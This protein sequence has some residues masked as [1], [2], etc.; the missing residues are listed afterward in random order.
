[1]THVV[2]QETELWD[3]RDIRLAN[4]KNPCQGRLEV[5]FNGTWGTVCSDSFVMKNAE[6]VCTQLNCGSAASVK[7]IAAFGEGSGPIWLDDVKCRSDDSLLWQCPSSPWGQH[8]CNH[9]EDVAVICS[10][11]HPSKNRIEGNRKE[12]IIYSVPEISELR[13]VA[14]F[15]NCSGRVEVFFGGTWGTL[16]DDSWDSQDAAVVCKQLN[17]GYPVLASGGRMFAQGNGTIWMDEVK[18]K[19]SEFFLWDCQF[20]A[21]GRHD[22][23]YKE[24]VGVICSGY[25]PHA[26]PFSYL[27]VFIYVTPCILGSLLVV[28][29]LYLVK[30]LLRGFR[31][32]VRKLQPSLTGFPEPFYEE[33]GIQESGA[34]LDSQSLGSENKLQYYVD[35]DLHEHKNENV[36]G[37]FS[38]PDGDF[39]EEY[40]DAE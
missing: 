33:I 20:S 15:D 14:G 12:T 21:M 16:C 28:M 10:E 18:C 1:M 4:G 38:P 5:F 6:V 2:C 37:A 40:D 19:G 26:A 31:N 32:G 9:G 30:G 36:E 17:C 3:H 13:L 34:V 23:G 39:G 29:S 8:N 22:C 25:Q 27:R 35:S 24:D 11:S 7:N